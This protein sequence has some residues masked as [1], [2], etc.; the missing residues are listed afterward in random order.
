MRIGLV[1]PAVPSYS[2][3]FFKSKIAGLVKSGHE[4]ILFVRRS[5]SRRFSDVKVV[6]Q[7]PVFGN[8]IVQSIVTVLGICTIA[9]MRPHRCYRFFMAEV[10]C[11]RPRRQVLEN[12]YVN[13]H[14]FAHSIDWLHFGFITMG[15]RREN[16]GKAANCKMSA[17]I[18]GYDI[19]IYPLKQPGCYDLLWQTLDK[20]HT[21][22]DDLVKTARGLGLP[23]SL[24][25]QKI[26]PAIVYREFDAA[27]GPFLSGR[28]RI[29][30]VA[31][32]NWK[33]G[34][35]YTL[36]GLALLR[37]SYGVDFE[38]TI[39]G[40]GEERERIIYA[41]YQLGIGDKVHLAGRVEQDR[42][43]ALMGE[44]DIYIQYSVQEGFC[45]AVLEAQASGMICVVSDAEG[46]P[47]NVVDNVTGFIVPRR[48]PVRLAKKL[49]EVS[50]LSGT[51]LDA[52]SRNAR[53]RV[54]TSFD[55][56]QQRQKFL[57]FFSIQD[58]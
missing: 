46:L 2:E 30:T 26:T 50:K 15:L 23:Q 21:I 32:L 29:L 25:V 7:W 51:E 8:R 40:A 17:S 36:E 54:R 37:D 28:L 55:I 19:G 5:S 53:E 9:M 41:S 6:K 24:H 56:E 16:V 45:N 10:R 20:V 27:R 18:R 14:I 43:I 4:V 52:M 49:W 48:S 42:V 31:R 47:E 39:V 57:E 34:L 11:G 13:A 38:Y 22:S 12:M 33:K 3:T 58:L 44:R 35:I 1:I